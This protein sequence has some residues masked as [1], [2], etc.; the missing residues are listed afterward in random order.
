MKLKERISVW[1]GKLP[2]ANKCHLFAEPIDG[3]SADSAA[4]PKKG[5]V[6]PLFTDL[7]SFI[8]LLAARRTSPFVSTHVLMPSMTRKTRVGDKQASQADRPCKFRAQVDMSTLHGTT[9]H[10]DDLALEL[11]PLY[12]TCTTLRTTYKPARL[13]IPNSVRKT[14]WWEL[15]GGVEKRERMVASC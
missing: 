6:P 5:S 8:P 12:S 15:K 9:D 1:L 13:L 14:I 4:P 3:I 2:P 11:L 10:I 7:D